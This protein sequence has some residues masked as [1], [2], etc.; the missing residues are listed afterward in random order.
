MTEQLHNSLDGR[1]FV[2]RAFTYHLKKVIKA[3]LVEKQDDGHY[4]LTMKGRRVGK[5]ALKKE[6]RLLDRAFNKRGP[7]RAPG[8]RARDDRQ[9]ALRRPVDRPVLQ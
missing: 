8:R 1:S 3:G 2:R 4:T 9:S 5:G 6:S 7:H